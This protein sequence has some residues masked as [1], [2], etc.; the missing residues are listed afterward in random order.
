V[1]T[2]QPPKPARRRPYRAPSLRNRVPSPAPDP[3]HGASSSPERRLPTASQHL[4]AAP[5]SIPTTR[6]RVRPCDNRVR[7][8]ADRANDVR[9]VP[10]R[11]ADGCG[12]G[13]VLGH[14]N[15]LRAR[16]YPAG[17]RRGSP[18]AHR[19]RHPARHVGARA[20]E[21]QRADRRRPRMGAPLLQPG[22]AVR[23][24]APLRWRLRGPARG[25]RRAGGTGGDE[26]RLLPVAAPPCRWRRCGGPHVGQRREQGA[27]GPRRSLGV[28]RL[29]GVHA[30]T[31]ARRTLPP[32]RRPDSHG[33]GDQPALRPRRPHRD[34]PRRTGGLHRPRGRGATWNGPSSP[35]TPSRKADR[36][37]RSH[38]PA[39][40]L[41][42]PRQRPRLRRTGMRSRAAGARRRAP[43]ASR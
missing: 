5:P 27:R 23:M 25:G 10:R 9:F 34:R 32:H 42:P 20:R 36:P 2:A 39:E 28:R 19:Y 6:A 14:P 24:P 33:R 18:G 12:I 31:R 7:G 11:P 43:P 21:R 17:V 4:D 26:Q 38:A 30:R 15:D 29:L 41:S 37:R 13:L 40:H 16:E 35:A 3:E 1:E 22:T 8:P